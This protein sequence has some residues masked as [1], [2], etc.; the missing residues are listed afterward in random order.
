MISNGTIELR[1]P[2]PFDIDDMYRWENDESIWAE[3]SQRAPMSRKTLADYVNCYNPDP[4]ATGQLRLV[5]ELSDTGEAIGCVDLYEYDAFNRR[6]GVGI[7]IDSAHQHK[8]YGRMTVSL[9]ADYARMHLGLHQ[10]W[11]IVSR[12]NVASGAMFEACGFRS[13]GS[14]RSWIRIGTTWNDA[15]MYQLLL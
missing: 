9:L 12:E 14:L 15:L 13:C 1:A 4:N 8:G 2:E 5:I 6:S 10:L 7:V 11:A 3:G